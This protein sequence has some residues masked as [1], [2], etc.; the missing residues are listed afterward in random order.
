MEAWKPSKETLISYMAGDTEQQADA[1]MHAF[2]NRPDDLTEYTKD[3]IV[4]L[5]EH[6]EHFAT[7][8]VVEK[9]V[10]GYKANP[11]RRKLKIKHLFNAEKKER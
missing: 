3:E 6:P 11:T 7:V 4:E 9:T 10:N 8:V 1:K 5:K 2:F